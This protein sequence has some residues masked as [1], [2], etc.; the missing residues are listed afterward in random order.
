MIEPKELIYPHEKEFLQ[1][2]GQ[3]LKSIA[4]VL[5]SDAHYRH[6]AMF[7]RLVEPERMVTFRVPWTDDRGRIRVNRGFRVE[8]NS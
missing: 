7:E 3:H 5:E 1:A 2:V 6:S 4:P 8:M